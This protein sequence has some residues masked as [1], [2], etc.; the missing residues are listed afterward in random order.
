MASQPAVRNDASLAWDTPQDG[1]AQPF[2]TS[3]SL[4]SGLVSRLVREWTENDQ[5]YWESKRAKA[6][7]RR[8]S[9]LPLK[10]AHAYRVLMERSL[11]LVPQGHQ[12][13]VSEH[14][15]K[16]GLDKRAGFAV[17]HWS[18]VAGLRRLE[19]VM[20]YGRPGWR[21]PLRWLLFT[22]ADHAL[23]RMFY[24]LKTT[25]DKEVLTELAQASRIFCAWY[26]Y[27]ITHLQESMSIGVPTP[28]GMLLV[29]RTPTC[30]RF[31]PFGSTATTWVNDDL[32]EARKAQAEP[33]REARLHGGLV[34]QVGDAYFALTH[35]SNLD[36]FSTS[37]EP[38]AN[39]FYTEMIRHLPK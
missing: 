33:L 17:V 14:G 24:R 4:A 3:E 37:F 13:I 36:R 18:V 21:L 10:R 15:D 23:Q 34:M 1:G 12:L 22:L 19:V 30:E 28:K 2:S 38:H 27:L 7:A 31:T 25:S 39:V 26:P 35:D 11:G 6:G 29:K 32:I 20:T 9:A 16:S 8:I 5:R